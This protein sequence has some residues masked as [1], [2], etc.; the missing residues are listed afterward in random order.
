MMLFCKNELIKNDS[1]GISLYSEWETNTKQKDIS[2][3][4]IKL[5]NCQRHSMFLT[6]ANTDHFKKCYF[7]YTILNKY[8]CTFEYKIMYG[9]K[10]I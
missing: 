10:L 1:V 7:Q 6:I 3:I 2:Q 4:K 5:I 9:W 8:I